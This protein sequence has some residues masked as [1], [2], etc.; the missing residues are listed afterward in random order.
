MASRSFPRSEGTP[1]LILQPFPPFWISSFPD[2]SCSPPGTPQYEVVQCST[3]QLFQLE[4]D[5]CRYSLVVIFSA[6]AFRRSKSC[7]DF[8]FTW[9][10]GRP[11]SRIFSFF[12]NLQQQLPL[13]YHTLITWMVSWV[14]HLLLV[15]NIKTFSL[16]LQLFVWLAR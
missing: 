2:F 14:C 3:P 11:Y 8:S 7:G 16:L 4:I 10:R 5:K 1:A 9:F 12:K 13:L 15:E 6:L